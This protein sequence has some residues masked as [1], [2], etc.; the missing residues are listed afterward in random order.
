MESLLKLVRFG[1]L[2]RFKRELPALLNS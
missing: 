1:Y 2:G